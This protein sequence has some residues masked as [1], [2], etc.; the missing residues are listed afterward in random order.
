MTISVE[1]PPP[2]SWPGWPELAGPAALA[3]LAKSPAPDET[4]P[5]VTAP[6]VTAPAEAAPA[7]TGHRSCSACLVA[8]AAMR[9]NRTL[10]WDP[11]G[12]KF[13]NDAEAQAMVSR[14]QRAPY[15]TEYVKVPK[16]SSRA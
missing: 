6:A 4:A 8:H 12:E 7:E 14:K 10:K 16:Q 13:V 1:S 5:A 3:D 9:L 2:P 11:A 15:G